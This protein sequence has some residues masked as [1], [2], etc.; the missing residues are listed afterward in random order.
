MSTSQILTT[1]ASKSLTPLE[2]S[3]L[4]LVCLASENG[5]FY[6]PYIASPPTPPAMSMLLMVATT[7]SKVRLHWHLPSQVGGNGSGDGQ[8]N[9]PDGITTDASGNVYVQICNNRIQKFDSTG[10][11][12]T[13]GA[14]LARQMGV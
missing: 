5:K 14:P 1:T 10:T 7:A 8:F 9:G 3:Y 6:F 11:F 4:N 13:N 12:L 2:L